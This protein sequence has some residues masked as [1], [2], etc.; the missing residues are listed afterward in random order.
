VAERVRVREITNQEGNRLLR[1]V[2]RS[3]GSVVTWRRAQMVLLSAQGMDVAQIAQVTFT[4][5]DRVRDVLHNFNLDGFDSLYP[6]YRGGRPPTFTLAQRRAIKRLALSRPQDHDLPFST[7]SLAKLAEFLVAE[8][9]V[10][11]ISHE[12]LR[13]LLRE[14]SVSF[15]RLKTWKQSTDPDFEAKK[16]RILHLYGLMDG[17]SDVGDGDPEVVICVDEFGPLNLQP[18]PGRQWTLTAGGGP[19]PRRRRRATYTRPHGVR[20]LLAAYDLSRDRLYGHV[21]PRKRR[22][23]FLVF[24]C[25]LRTLYPPEVRLGLVLDNYSPHLS[26][27]D[28]PRVGQWAQANNVELAYTPT[29]ASW[30][31]R[32]EAQFTALRYFALDGTDHSSH[33][34][35][36]SMIRRYVAWRNRNARDRRLGEIINRANV[37]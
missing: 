1:I 5:T 19:R 18:H 28:D 26:T 25:Y 8:G 20:H 13:A 23:E 7:W 31:N 14:Q 35:Q 4:S 37:A 24:L 12:G 22:G 10:D 27:S 30:L 34:E 36:A 29:N 17:T 15:Q 16:D 33:A 32:I 6:R 2:R 9:V 11:D 3:S 21:K